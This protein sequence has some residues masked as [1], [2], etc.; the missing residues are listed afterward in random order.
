MA[1][2]S[3]PINTVSRENL[4]VLIRNNVMNTSLEFSPDPDVMET[5]SPIRKQTNLQPISKKLFHSPLADSPKGTVQRSSLDRSRKARKRKQTLLPDSCD[6]IKHAYVRECE[7][8]G[9]SPDV[10]GGM[11]KKVLISLFHNKEY[12][13]DFDQ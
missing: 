5:D 9:Y 7:Q 12:S 2:L 1:A 3:T 6:V 4:I 13:M 8:D 11:R 10:Y